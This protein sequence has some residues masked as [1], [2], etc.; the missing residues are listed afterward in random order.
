MVVSIHYGIFEPYISIEG[1]FRYQTL[2][3]QYTILLVSLQSQYGRH[4]IH[5]SLA[6]VSGITVKGVAAASEVVSNHTQ[7]HYRILPA[8]MFI[9]NWLSKSINKHHWSTD[10]T[11]SHIVIMLTKYALHYH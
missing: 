11:C 5:C 7:A 10:L 3:K 4:L 2:Y 1:Y 9:Y 6:D 8:N